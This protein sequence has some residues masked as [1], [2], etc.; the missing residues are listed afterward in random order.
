MRLDTLPG[1][2]AAQEL[3]R[4]LG[5]VEIEPYRHNPIAGSRFMEL[6]LRRS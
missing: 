6:D 2:D 4:T 1:M 5:F 3:Y